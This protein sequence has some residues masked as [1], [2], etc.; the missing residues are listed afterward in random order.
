MGV[1]TPK[2][3]KMI[4]AVAPDGAPP[5]RI[6]MVEKKIFSGFHDPGVNRIGS[7]LF[8]QNKKQ[9][10]DVRD[11]GMRYPRLLTSVISSRTCSS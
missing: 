10:K 8:L 9:R 1:E 11:Q 7:G 4:N 5:R 2:P 3:P 6:K